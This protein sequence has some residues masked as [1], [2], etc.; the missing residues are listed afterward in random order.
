MKKN[1][2][3][4]TFGKIVSYIFKREKLFVFEHTL[5]DLS[6]K[7]QA[8][9]E[10]DVNLV[11]QDDFSKFA[12]TFKDLR[13]NADERFKM[14]HLCFGAILNG[15]YVHLKWITFNELYVEEIDR[16][17]RVSSGAAYMYD[18]YTLPNYRGL[19]ISSK[20][21]EKTVQHLS[22]IGMKRIYAVVRHNNF[23]MLK[24]K[25]KEKARKIGTITYT[26]II[27][28]RFYRFKGET[29]EDHKKI[30]DMFSF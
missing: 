21:M 14:G 11:S 19:G 30:A 27:G 12:K 5:P 13:K 7:S 16:K 28:F 15:E 6:F 20:V 1:S 25:Q 24:V 3:R 4:F 2:M 10:V 18:S 17:I 22:K 29:E 26:K 9:V 23:P 8:K